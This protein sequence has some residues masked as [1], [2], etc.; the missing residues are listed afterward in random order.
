MEAEHLGQC[1]EFSVGDI[2]GVQ[3][4][5]QFFEGECFVLP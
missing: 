5:L 4:S 1:L 2:F 3:D